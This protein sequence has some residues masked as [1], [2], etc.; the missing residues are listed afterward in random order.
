MRKVVVMGVGA[1]IAGK[2]PDKG[3]EALGREA[4]DAAVKDMGVNPKELQIGYCANLFAGMIPG[5][6]IFRDAGIADI[7]IVN[8]ENACAG[9]ATAF[10]SLYQGIAAG[11]YDIGIAVGVESMT[12]SPIAGKLIPPADDDLEGQMGMVMPAYFALSARRHMEEYGTTAE[13]FAKISV[14]NHHHGCLNPYSQYKKE[15]TVEE[16]LGSRMICDPITLFEC[17]PNTDGAAAAILCSE[18]IAK[19][20]DNE[21]IYVRA[22]ALKMGDYQFKLKDLSFSDLTHKVAQEAY[23][24]AG[25]GPEDID[26]CELH[27]AFASAELL[28]YEELGFCGRGEGGRLIDEGITELG[29]K[30]AVNASGG[31]LSKGHPL[32]ATGVAQMVEITWQLRGQAGDRQALNAKVGMTHTMGGTAAGIEAGACSIHILST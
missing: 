3:I 22:S 14:K 19:K 16:I 8:V 5:Q 27:D 30:I 31:L 10:R 9:G 21:P 1:T 24:M 11:L 29:G 17:C 23:E 20:Y 2:L 6:R 15:M 26:V 13:Q 4:V 18:D 7:E 32:S 12:T 28:H 25:C